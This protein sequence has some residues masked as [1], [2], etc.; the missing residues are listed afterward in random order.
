MTLMN[1]DMLV[2]TRMKLDVVTAITNLDV[3]VIARNATLHNLFA[4][5]SLTYCGCVSHPKSIHMH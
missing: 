1:Y 5:L 4:L 3:M 2:V